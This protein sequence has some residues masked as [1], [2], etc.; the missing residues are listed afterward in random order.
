MSWGMVA[1][2]A[3]TLGA[4]YMA[5]RSSSKDRKAASEASAESLAFEQERYDDWRAT[6]GP[7]EDNLAD[8]YNKVSPSYYA[9]IGLENFEQQMSTSMER[10]RENFAQRGINPSSGIVASL[11]SQAE[12]SSAEKRA[13]IRRDAP[14][15]AVEDQSR[16]LQIGMGQNPASSVSNAFANQATAAHNK[17]QASSSAAGTAWAAA[18]PAVGR[19]IDAYNTRNEE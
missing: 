11:E 3:G 16:F 8:Y 6:Y 12:L 18:I 14:R 2:G 10:L 15:Q 1:V 4:G 9:A 17:A 19:G 13:S 5:S 7:L